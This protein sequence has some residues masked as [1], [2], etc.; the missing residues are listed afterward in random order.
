MLSKGLGLRGFEGPCQGACLGGGAWCHPDL[1]RRPLLP[2]RAAFL[3]SLGKTDVSREVEEVL[4]EGR[5]RRTIRPVSV[6]DAEDAPRPLAGHHRGRWHGLLPAL[7]P[8]CGER[9]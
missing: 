6:P 5:I 1:C 8:Q 7:R 2:L 9:P 4:A 3:T